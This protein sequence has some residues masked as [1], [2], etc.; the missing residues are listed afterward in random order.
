[1][2][3]IGLL[4]T[5]V[6][7]AV[8]SPARADEAP[9][10]EA[11]AEAAFRAQRW[12]EAEALFKRILAERGAKAPPLVL[13]NL[14]IVYDETRRGG[15]FTEE[16][17]AL[18]RRAIALDP[19]LGVAHFRLA[20]H[21]YEDGH[22][23]DAIPIFRQAAALAGPHAAAAHAWL[24]R[25]LQSYNSEEEPGEIVRLFRRAIALDSSEPTPYLL[26]GRRLA[27]EG[28]KAEALA[29]LRQGA[30]LPPREN[31]DF[32]SEIKQLVDD[33]AQ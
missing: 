33:G 23:R 31:L 12:I 3:A 26:L 2:R 10:L 9:S 1:M 22:G 16:A 11:R 13:C 32:A 7:I 25:L 24:A 4:T 21:L 19:K 18:Y 5:G 6:L 15:A 8:A 27:N 20:L 29:I 30:K 17:E 14:A 28:R